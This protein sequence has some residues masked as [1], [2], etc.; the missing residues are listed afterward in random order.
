MAETAASAAVERGREGLTAA[1]GTID[2]TSPPN[3]AISL[4]RLE[5]TKPFSTDVMKNTESTSGAST[6]LLWA[7]C[8]SESKS[9]IARRP[10]TIAVAPRA[11]QKSTVSPSNEAT[12]KRSGSICSASARR[13]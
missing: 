3:D 12:S 2:D 10:R 5:L 6:R 13:G 7:S 4:T 8:I 9:L 1:A 11:W